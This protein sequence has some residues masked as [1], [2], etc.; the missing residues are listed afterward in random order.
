MVVPANP[1]SVTELDPGGENMNFLVRV[2]S[3]P[4]ALLFKVALAKFCF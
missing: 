4:H 1:G 3:H 2:V